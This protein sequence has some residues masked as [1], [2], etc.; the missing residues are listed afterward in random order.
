MSD[1]FQTVF[2]QHTGTDSLP[3]QRVRYRQMQKSVSETIA[4]QSYIYNSLPQIRFSQSCLTR[5][6]FNKE[7]SSFPFSN[8]I[9]AHCS[10][11]ATN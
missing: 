10:T 1:V 5:Q 7:S 3:Y 8:Y 11:D 4:I 9:E 2:A 6:R